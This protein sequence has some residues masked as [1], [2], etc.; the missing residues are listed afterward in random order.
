M[1]IHSYKI[2]LTYLFK[3]G[4]QLCFLFWHS[5][6]LQN[7]SCLQFPSVIYNLHILKLHESLYVYKFQLF[8]CGWVGHKHLFLKFQ[9]DLV[10]FIFQTTIILLSSNSIPHNTDE[11]NHTIIKKGVNTNYTI[12]EHPK[13][14]IK[15]LNTVSSTIQEVGS[16]E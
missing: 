15:S 8:Y 10:E 7:H 1:H 5:D 3:H 6:N 14:Y 16:H 11:W 13:A 12:L 9:I 2:T 4:M